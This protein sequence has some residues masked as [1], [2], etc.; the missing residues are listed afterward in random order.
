MSQATKKIEV[1]E[2]QAPSG[3]SYRIGMREAMLGAWISLDK[4]RAWE[5]GVRI[6]PLIWIGD[7]GQVSDLIAEI[8]AGQE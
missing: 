8:E 2:I 6:R 1:F 7:A 5:P 3:Q 4:S